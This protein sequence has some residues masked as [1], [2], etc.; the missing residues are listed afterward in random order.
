ML[1]LFILPTIVFAQ[2]TILFP[3]YIRGFGQHKECKVDV[4][5]MSWSQSKGTVVINLKDN[6]IKIGILNYT[7]I[8]K[9]SSPDGFVCRATDSGNEKCKISYSKKGKVHL[10]TVLQNGVLFSYIDYL[11]SF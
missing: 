1:F 2:N 5:K 4:K 11:G 8:E 3:Y 6:T 7:I 9:V 10:I